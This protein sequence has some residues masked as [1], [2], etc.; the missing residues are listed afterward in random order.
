[1]LKRALLPTLGI[2]AIAAAAPAEAKTLANGIML[3]GI[4]LNGL[5]L[6][7]IMLNGS[8]PGSDVVLQAVRLTLPD[9][10]ELTFR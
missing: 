4:M 1:V 2:I 5:A 10:A 8:G 3:N 9:G 7:G 6:N